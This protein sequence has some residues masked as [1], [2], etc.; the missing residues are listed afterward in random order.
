M[1]IKG[2]R[3]PKPEVTGSNPVG[4]ATLRAGTNGT[5]YRPVSWRWAIDPSRRFSDS[6]V[7]RRA[8]RARSNATRRLRRPAAT[9]AS[10]SCHA[11][12]LRP[13]F[14]TGNPGWPASFLALGTDAPSSRAISARLTTNSAPSAAAS[15]V[16]TSLPRSCRASA[17]LGYRVVREERWRRRFPGSF[18]DYQVIGSASF[19]GFG[20]ESLRNGKPAEDLVDLRFLPEVVPA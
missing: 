17:R 11:S 9:A 13:S 16:E 12:P 15:C 18:W 10:S 3:P 14:G 7:S 20:R 8:S 6:A 19:R 1:R 4:C 5:R 2:S